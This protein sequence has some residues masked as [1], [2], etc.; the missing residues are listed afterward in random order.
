MNVSVCLANMSGKPMPM[1]E[2]MMVGKAQQN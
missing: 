2:I 1:P